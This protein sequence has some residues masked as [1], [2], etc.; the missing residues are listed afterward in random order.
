M[1]LVFLIFLQLLLVC[2]SVI[3]SHAGDIVIDTTPQHFATHVFVGPD[4]AMPPDG[5]LFISI[6]PTLDKNGH[7]YV[8]R[9]IPEAL[10]EMRQMFPHWFIA[11][12]FHP[13]D[14][15]QQ[16]LVLV[17]NY[18]VGSDVM[19]WIWINWALD[20]KSSP[21]KKALGKHGIRSVNVRAAL[22]VGFCAYVRTDNIDTGMAAIT[23]FDERNRQ[24]NV[25]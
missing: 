22:Y 4:E 14:K 7:Y 8:P 2:C 21:L 24:S 18:P 23:K 12:L 9:D 19:D 25:R 3:G 13:G 20:A 16:C 1:R 6:Q 10:V 17:N 15:D 11:A 5:K